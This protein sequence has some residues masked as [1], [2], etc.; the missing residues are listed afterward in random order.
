MLVGGSRVPADEGEEEHEVF[1]VAITDNSPYLDCAHRVKVKLWKRSGNKD[2]P[3]IYPSSLISHNQA[4]NSH[5]R[6]HNFMI[7][8]KGEKD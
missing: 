4:T 5:C 8:E 6:W 3:I 7:V 1:N 2:Q